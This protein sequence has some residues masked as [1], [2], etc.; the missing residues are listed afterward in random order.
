MTY[1]VS[2]IDWIKLWFVVGFVTV[3]WT[4]LAEVIPPHYYKAVSVVLQAVQAA[5]LFAARGGKYVNNR[6]EPPAGGQP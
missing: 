1:F 5:I 6:T 4:G 2:N 3:L